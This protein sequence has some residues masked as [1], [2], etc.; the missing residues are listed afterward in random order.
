MIDA[1]VTERRAR[2]HHPG[3]HEEWT[4]STGAVQQSAVNLRGYNNRLQVCIY[5]V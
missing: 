2:H 5:F 3:W 4:R 1:T